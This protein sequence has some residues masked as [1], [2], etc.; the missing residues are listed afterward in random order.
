[1]TGNIMYDCKSSGKYYH[2]IRLMGR[3]ASNITLETALQTRPNY[4]LISEEVRKEGM[5]L[6][7]ITKTLCDLICKRHN[8]QKDHGV[9]LVPEIGRAVQ[10]E[11]RDRSRMPSSA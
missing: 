5:T 2:F 11:C 4:T 8:I 7:S 9:I 3:E 10:Q 1:M 6:A